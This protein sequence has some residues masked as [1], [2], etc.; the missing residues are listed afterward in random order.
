MPNE[1][2]LQPKE[3]PKEEKPKETRALKQDNMA[4]MNL[5]TTMF[6]LRRELHMAEEH[7]ARVS[8]K[9]SRRGT[10]IFL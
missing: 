4:P 8:H 2:V 1:P 5:V 3:E 7:K 9:R 10:R 6:R